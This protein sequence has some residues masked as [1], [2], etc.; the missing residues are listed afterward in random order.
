MEVITE[1]LLE[2]TQ[3]EEQIKQIY[4]SNTANPIL[5]REKHINYLVQSL[6]SLPE[7]F[8]SLDA[9]LPW[10][11]YWILHSLD[12]LEA[13]DTPRYESRYLAMLFN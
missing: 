6:E 11:L 9:S 2:Q 12:L 10:I 13:L 5:C 8:T 4:A 1:T 7:Y 3:V